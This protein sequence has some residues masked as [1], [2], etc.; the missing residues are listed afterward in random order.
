MPTRA[1]LLEMTVAHI[2]GTWPSTAAVIQEFRL[3]CIGCSLD[4]FCTI[5]EVIDQYNLDG[6]QM[7]GQ[8]ERAIGGPPLE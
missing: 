1:A 7:L 5:A 8:L 3:A 6:D 4:E 2:L